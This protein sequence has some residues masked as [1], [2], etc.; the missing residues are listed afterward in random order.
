MDKP[1]TDEPPSD[2][3]PP[4]KSSFDR[5]SSDRSSSEVLRLQR[6]LAV[7]ALVLAAVLGM[8]GEVLLSLL[9]VFVGLGILAL[10]AG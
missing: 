9:V 4:D 2:N 8:T 7:R 3:P 10:M 5:P 1:S 6:H